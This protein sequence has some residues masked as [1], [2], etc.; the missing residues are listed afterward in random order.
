MAINEEQS[1]KNT[2]YE[3]IETSLEAQLR[4][5]RR[6]RGNNKELPPK[7]GMSQVDMAYNILEKIGTPLHINEIIH[8]IEITHRIQVDRES[9]VSAI[10]K[11]VQRG[12][13]F[14]KVGKNTFEAKK[15]NSSLS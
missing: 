9:L 2:I 3:A 10:T 6:L 15:H 12:D 7:R 4:A 5:I 11:K 1:L 14:S 13:R 8:N